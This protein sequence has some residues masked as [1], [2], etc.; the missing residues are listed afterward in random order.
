MRSVVAA[1]ESV[2]STRRSKQHSVPSRVIPRQHAESEQSV[3]T[4]Q[5]NTLGVRESCQVLGKEA[6]LHLTEN[7]AH[8]NADSYTSRLPFCNAKNPPT[9]NTLISK[10][11]WRPS[12]PTS[13]SP[14]SRQAR[15][16]AWWSRQTSPSRAS[17]WS[18]SSSSSQPTASTLS[19]SRS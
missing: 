19:Y 3:K 15:H 6:L 13:S 14:S 11:P 12:S 5:A 8:V 7:H 17:N 10:K 18:S 1:A 2:S 9:L 4:R 16:R